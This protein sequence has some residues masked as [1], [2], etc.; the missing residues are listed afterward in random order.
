MSRLQKAQTG[1]EPLLARGSPALSVLTRQNGQGDWMPASSR[2]Q[3]SS[4]EFSPKRQLCPGAAMH[5]SEIRRDLSFLF[6]R[7]E[8]C[9]FSFGVWETHV[10]SF[11][12]AEAASLPEK[13]WGVFDHNGG[14]FLLGGGTSIPYPGK[15]CGVIGVTPDWVAGDARSTR[16]LSTPQ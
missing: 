10:C 11:S 9:Q 1:N 5:A 3:F 15:Q 8:A 4:A 16:D 14:F 2:H 7:A 12:L 13:S 6:C